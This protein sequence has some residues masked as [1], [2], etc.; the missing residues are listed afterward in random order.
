MAAHPVPKAALLAAIRKFQNEIRENAARRERYQPKSSRKR[1]TPRPTKAPEELGR[2]LLILADRLS[3][4]PSWKSYTWRDDL[5]SAG[6][7]AMLYA[8]TKFNTAA[9]TSPFS[10]LTTS[11]WRAFNN[12]NEKQKKRGLTGVAD[13][14]YEVLSFPTDPRFGMYERESA[15]EASFGLEG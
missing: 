12:A 3:H 1:P 10:Y 5:V 15:A 2:L 11:C 7:V 8:C 6:V 4:H 9:G 13:R 14:E